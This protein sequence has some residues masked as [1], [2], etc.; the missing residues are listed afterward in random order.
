V[1]LCV[2]HCV[3]LPLLDLRSQFCSSVATDARFYWVFDFILVD[4]LSCGS[5]AASGLHLC[6]SRSASC[7][8]LAILLFCCHHVLVPA[9]FIRSQVSL[10]SQVGSVLSAIWS[11][12]APAVRPQGPRCCLFSHPTR[13]FF[14]RT[15]FLCGTPGPGNASCSQFLSALVTQFA[16]GCRSQC[17][18]AC[19]RFL[20]SCLLPYS[21]FATTVVNQDGFSWLRA[22]RLDFVSK[23]KS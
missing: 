1:L 3:I 20:H 15:L 21:V 17:S 6:P 14:D 9:Q 22:A 7:R 16:S 2:V 8:S 12:H 19:S 13:V 23:S 10:S 4:G 5:T 11:G 18:A